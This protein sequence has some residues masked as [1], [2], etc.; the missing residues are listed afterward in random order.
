MRGVQDI[1][2]HSGCAG[3]GAL[4]Y[5]SYMK[6]SILEMEKFR[7][8]KEKQSALDKIA[9]ID[10]RFSEIEVEQRA[11]FAALEANG[12]RHPSLPDVTDPS[13]MVAPRTKTGSFKI[14]Y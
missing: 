9:Q 14:K 4:S 11:I 1:K 2:T 6:I 8:G 3:E 12:V 5:K 7:K 10:K 13:T